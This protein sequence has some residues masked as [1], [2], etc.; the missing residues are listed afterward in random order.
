MCR[1]PIGMSS[2]KQ[3]C[4]PHQKLSNGVSHAT[5]M[6]RNWVDSRFFV[7][8]SQIVGLTS[9]LS[10]GHNLCFKCPNGSCKPILDIYVSIDFQWYK[11][12]LKAMG[13]DP[14]N[15]SLKIWESTRTPTPK[16]GAHLGVWMFILTLSHTPSWPAHLQTL[17][18]VV[19][20]RLRLRQYSIA[21]TTKPQWESNLL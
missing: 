11:D 6:Q 9:G 18:L 16:M 7:V 12:F 17:A 8:G 10:F 4:S 20:Q 15:C 2:I 14:C 5:C 3:S 13:L 19:S 1:L 21:S